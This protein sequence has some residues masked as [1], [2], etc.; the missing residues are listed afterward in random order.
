MQ[1]LIE[2]KI[3]SLRVSLTNQQRIVVLKQV[4]ADRFLPIW[5]GPYEAE[6]ITIALQEI[7]VSRPQTHDLLNSMIGQLGGRLTR[8]EISALKDDIFFGT[9][10]IEKDGKEIEVD[11]RP[12]DAIAVAV[13]AH[14]P[15]LVSSKVMDE[16]SIIPEEINETSEEESPA[17]EGKPSVEAESDTKV[18]FDDERLSI[19]EEYFKNKDE[20]DSGDEEKGSQTDDSPENK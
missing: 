16:A 5:I 9:L 19:F 1:Q 11:S 4:D 17:G 18:S 15:I 10:V 12:S 7:E 2:V 20:D 13:R 3:D 14:V 8:V 6:A